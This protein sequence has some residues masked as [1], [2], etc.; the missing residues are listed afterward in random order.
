[1]GPIVCPEISAR[2]NHYSLHNNPEQCSSHEIHH[3]FTFCQWQDWAYII[4]NYNEQDA[5]FL[6]LF[7][8]TDALHVSGTGTAWNM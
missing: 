1:M 7:I 8:S 5:M 2:N 3:I 6:D 4:L